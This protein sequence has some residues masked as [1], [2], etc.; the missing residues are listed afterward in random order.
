MKT[1]AAETFFSGTSNIVLPLKQSEFPPEYAG[2]SRLT[3]YA[4]LFSSLEV[5]ASFYKLPQAATV[6]RWRESVPE[7]FRFTFKVPKSITHAKGLQFNPEDVERFAEVVSEAGG[8]KGCLLVQ[9]PP[10]LKSDREEELEGLLESLS[11]D[12]PGWHIAVEFRHRSWYDK[13]VYRML[14]RQGAG[15]V[16]QDLPA[17]ATPNRSVSERF[18]YLRFHGPEGGYRGSYTPDFL[19]QQ[20]ERIGQWMGEGKDVYVYFNNTLG[21][22]LSN[23]QTLNELVRKLPVAGL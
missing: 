7:D 4:S 5:N 6:A 9:L 11:G 17:S 19:Q 15:M 18:A 13:P 8:R 22:A 12:T 20:A 10:S 14:Q 16:H 2:A 1:R 21:A 23:L 3:Y